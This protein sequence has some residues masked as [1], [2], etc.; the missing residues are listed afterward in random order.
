MPQ[1]DLP[2]KAGDTSCEV[3]RYEHLLLFDVNVCQD[4][5]GAEFGVLLSDETSIIANIPHWEIDA[6]ISQLQYAAD[7]MRRRQRMRLDGP[8]D[9]LRDICENALTPIKHDIFIHPQKGDIV[10]LHRFENHAPVA[11][12]MTPM[13][14][15]IARAKTNAAL[16]R[17]AN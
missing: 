15:K 13:D 5:S 10:F 7:E 16:A 2:C 12:K 4:G 11:I 8:A 17:M 6:V 14:L 9:S 3:N 1:Y